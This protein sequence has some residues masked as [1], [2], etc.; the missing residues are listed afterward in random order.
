MQSPWRALFDANAKSRP[1]LNAELDAL[2]SMLRQAAGAG[3]GRERQAELAQTL[4]GLALPAWL[5]GEIIS[6]HND[7]I[8][9]CAIER[10]LDQM[11]ADGWGEPP[12]G[13]CVI[14]MG[15]G[16]RH[17]SLLA[18][19]QD[20]G[21]ILGSYPMHR[22]NE[23]D[24]WFRTFAELFTEYLDQSGI[25]FCRGDVMASRPLWRKPVNEW[26]TQMRL[27][28]AGRRV[29]QVQQCNILFDF[30]PVYGD[31]ALVEPVREAIFHSVPT[32]GLFLNEMAELLD[33]VPVALD[34][35]DRLQG[36]GRE[37]PHPR[38]INLKRQGL[39]PM[40]AALRLLALVYGCREVAT[41]ERL[42]WLERTGVL[43]PRQGQALAAVFERLVKLLLEA[44]TER[45][46]K[47]A[48]PDNWIDTEQLSALEREQLR[49]DLKAVRSLVRKA[50]QSTSVVSSGARG[51]S[52]T[53]QAPPRR[54]DL[55]I[56]SRPPS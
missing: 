47:G 18:P 24:T 33:E 3:H 4:S 46:L 37:A 42:F 53:K 31:V 32:A 26:Q 17:E 8:Y 16:G 5:I 2:L 49:F 48:R 20:N 38:A 9:H 19:D 10:A 44:Q 22:H 28:M 1:Y 14:V 11:R 39:L 30:A 27:W 54:S 25:P 52:R 55:S 15:S 50:G 23:V 45:S 36:D 29:K 40:T 51:N 35:L 21:L 41:R 6:D 7:L 43:K 13:F 12:V 34:R 56:Q